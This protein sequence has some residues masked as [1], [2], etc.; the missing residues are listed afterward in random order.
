MRS[1]ARARSEMGGDGAEPPPALRAGERGP[2]ESRLETGSRAETIPAAVS[3]VIPTRNRRA[4]LLRTLRALA[5]QTLS[6]N[7]YEVVVVNDGSTDG[8]DEAVAGFAAPFAV[9]TVPSHGRGRAAA[10]NAGARAARG[11]L[12]VLL[13]DDMEPGEAFLESHL[14]E[15]VYGSRRGVIGAVPVSLGASETPVVRYIGEKFNRHLEKLE[16]SDYRVTFRD[17]YSGN[18]SIPRDLFL[19]V[20]GFDEEFR[21]YGNEDGDLALRLL[22]AGVE[23]RYSRDAVARQHYEKDFA[24]LARD[25]VAKGR[26]AVLLSRKWPATRSQLR[27]ARRTGSRKWRAALSG[28]LW[29]SGVAPFVP[30]LAIGVM[31]RVERRRPRRLDVYYRFA[32]DYFYLLG[33][34]SELAGRRGFGAPFEPKRR[35]PRPRTVV[36]Y[37][38]SDAFGGAEISLLTLLGGLDRRRWN[39]VLLHHESEGIRPLRE[40]AERLGVRVRAIPREEGALGLLRLAREIRSERAAVFHAHLP[41]ALRCGRGLVAAKLARVPAVVATQQLFEGV[42]SAR[43]ILRQWRTS[44]AV[45]R[46]VAVSEEIA[47]RLRATPLFPA[48]KIEVIANAADPGRFQSAADRSLRE[49]LAGSTDR[50]I[51][52]SLARLD[53]QK[54]LSDLL[55][56][57]VH[58]REASFVLAGEGPERHRLEE[59]VRSLGIGSRVRFLGYREDVPELLAACDI[60]VLPSVYEGLPISILEAMAAEKPVVATNIG[61]IREAVRDGETGLLVPPHDPAALSAAI[62]SVLQDP[63]LA[64]R[65]GRA[66]RERVLREFSAGDM[67]RKVTELYESVLTRHGL[68]PCEDG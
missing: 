34:R 62:R 55:E 9:R 16:R 17:F 13:D 8:T 53:P 32:L 29:I 57:A 7:E 59:T 47:A 5:N 1:S 65:L 22:H 24:A 54:G 63:G 23:I 19:Q 26:T 49:V 15:Q 68:A 40:A 33:A 36:H 58:V 35:I 12:L 64:R 39:P 41:W 37:V 27:F 52:L 56:A 2:S 25:N 18:F 67:V 60:V 38:D 51:V 43:V 10:C 45:D 31:K 4:S 28:L 21:I 50:P 3:V 11:T 44:L 20:G 46:Y 66:G 6:K 14:R 48:R 61:G 42:S 30:H